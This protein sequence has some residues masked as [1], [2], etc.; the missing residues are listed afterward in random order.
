LLETWSREKLREAA[1]VHLRPHPFEI[2]TYYN[3]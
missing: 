3:C 2:E 1:M